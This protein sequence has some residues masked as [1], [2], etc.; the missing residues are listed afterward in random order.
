MT[1]S[2]REL[3]TAIRNA[4]EHA[5]TTAYANWEKDGTK[6]SGTPYYVEAAIAAGAS[7]AE[8]AG[9]RE[10]ADDVWKGGCAIG[11]RYYLPDSK[12]EH[13]AWLYYLP[14][15]GKVRN[16]TNGELDTEMAR[17]G[18]KRT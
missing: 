17:F 1:T 6:I 3:V 13:K 8:S 11:I 2:D 7:A 9:V 14:K 5:H 4:L 12:E 15:D 10:L 16:I 18:K